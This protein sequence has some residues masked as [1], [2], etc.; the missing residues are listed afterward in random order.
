MKVYIAALSL[1]L[2]AFA[3]LATGVILKRR[4]LRGGCSPDPDSDQDCQCRSSSGPD[5][6]SNGSRCTGEHLYPGETCTDC[7]DKK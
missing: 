2:I 1:F 5:A 7:P 4:G 6:S 3:C